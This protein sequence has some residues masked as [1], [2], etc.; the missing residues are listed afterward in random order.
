MGRF[1]D[2]WI[3]GSWEGWFHLEHLDCDQEFRGQTGLINSSSV[4]MTAVE[5]YFDMENFVCI[6]NTV[7]KR[8]IF[9][10][11]LLRFETS[12]LDSL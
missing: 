12:Q 9:N 7:L 1:K 5:V 10:S 3:D 11:P 8:A 4:Q 2:S 6:I